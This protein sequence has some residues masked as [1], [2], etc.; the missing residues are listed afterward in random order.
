MNTEEFIKKAI[1][2]HGTKYDYSLVDYVNSRTKVRIVCPIH[3]EFLQT[4]NNHLRGSGCHLCGTERLRNKKEKIT[5]ENFIERSKLVHGD[6]YDYS[7]TVFNKSSEKVLITCPIH[8]DFS[9]LPFNHLHG[10]GCKKCANENTSFRLKKKTDKFIEDAKFVHGNKY[11]Y[12]LAVYRGAKIPV[13][14]VC[15][16]HGVFEQKPMDHLAGC[17]C[18]KCGVLSVWNKRGR[19]TTEE[20]IKKAREVH[21]DKYD[22]SKTVYKNN[23]TP[24]CIIC[25]KKRKDGTEH[26]EFWQKPNSHLNGSGCKRCRNS[27]L[28]RKFCLFLNR[29]NIKYTQEKTFDWLIGNG[30]NH[31]YYD[32]YLPEY[33]IAV[34]CQGIQHFIPLKEDAK[35]FKEIK[36]N[37][38]TKRKL[39]KENGV[40]LLFFSEKIICESYAN[41]SNDLFFDLTEIL[42]HIKG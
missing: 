2:V 13:K 21:G 37:D 38:S 40:K 19:I 15:L 11:D 32:F 14:I 3:G 22:Y 20:F 39:S 10:V 26:G 34:E 17:G 12:S 35:K 30:G 5:T 42:K 16:E 31:L 7:K 27:Q 23:R 8:G 18:P 28:E 24:V 41:N 6:K 33:N 4:P 25:H 29:Q 1:E 9:V 36:V